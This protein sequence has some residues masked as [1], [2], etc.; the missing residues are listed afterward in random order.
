MSKDKESEKMPSRTNLGDDAAGMSTGVAIVGFILCFLAGGA[1][2]WGYDAR[3][4]KEGI[5]GDTATAWSDD[6][7][8]IPIDSKDPMWGKRDAPVTIV[9]FSDFQ[10]PFCSRVEPTMDQVK[11]TYGPDKVRIIWKN[12]PL[13]F[14]PNAHPAAEAA[15]GVFAMKGNDAFW[16]W[17]DAAFKDQKSLGTDSYVKWAQSAGVTNVADYQ[18][19]L[20]SHKWADKVDKDNAEGKQVGV[21]GTPGFYINGVEVSGAQPFDKFKAVIDQELQKAQAKIASG[22]AKDKVYVAMTTENKKNAPA[23]TDEKE[24]EKEDSTT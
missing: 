17:H 1:L 23:K 20:S 12:N 19:G 4:M 14:H 15:E 13:P 5:S 9:Q 11:Q 2:M 3:R 10:C 21:N 24:D 18:A 7:S 6:D 22:T 8:P 16:K